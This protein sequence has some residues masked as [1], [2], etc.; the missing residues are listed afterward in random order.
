V[1]AAKVHTLAVKV[2][3]ELVEDH[4]SLA[5]PDQCDLRAAA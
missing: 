1:I 2:Q 3:G 4:A 5:E